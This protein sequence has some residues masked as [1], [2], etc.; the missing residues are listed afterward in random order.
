MNLVNV[1]PKHQ[2]DGLHLLPVDPV[3]AII[4]EGAPA[5]TRSVLAQVV[6]FGQRKRL[7][8]RPARAARVEDGTAP[9]TV[10]MSARL[11]HGDIGFGEA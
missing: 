11:L 2:H 7:Q 5:S 9:E 1:A 10:Q 3:R 4:H 6:H 8:P